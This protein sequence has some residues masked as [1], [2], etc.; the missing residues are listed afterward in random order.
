MLFRLAALSIVRAGRR[1][2]VIED[3]GSVGG[4]ARNRRWSL[5]FLPSGHGSPSR[6]RGGRE[7]QRRGGSGDHRRP[8]EIF[9]GR[10][11]FPYSEDPR[12]AAGGNPDPLPGVHEQRPTAGAAV[13]P[14]TTV[15]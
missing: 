3:R 11:L 12:H 10:L 1:W 7:L 13:G 5:R 14:T 4:F 9:R 8:P 2:A 6:R 15:L